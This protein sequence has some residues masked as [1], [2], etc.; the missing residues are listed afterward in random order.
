[1]LASKLQKTYVL[2]TGTVAGPKEGK[3]PFGTDFDLVFKDYYYGTRNFESA[4]EKALKEAANIALTKAKLQSTDIFISGDLNNQIYASSKVASKFDSSYLG[5][6]GACSTSMLGVGIASLLIEKDLVKNALISTSSLLPASERQFRYPNEYGLQKKAETTIT[7]SGAA[8]IILSNT[9]SR[10]KITEVSIGGAKD[11]G[12]DD[13]KD[14]GTAMSYAAFDTIKNHLNYFD[15]HASYYDLILTGDL[16]FYGSKVLEELFISE[17]IKLNNH[18]DS[19]LLLYAKDENV[20]AGGSGAACC[21]LVT[22][23]HIFKELK[24]GR[25]NRVLVV[26]TGALHNPVSVFQK[27]AIPAVA[28]AVVFE[29]S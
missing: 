9:P 12:F 23:T 26:A 20:F 13:V 27:K 6:F 16:S 10:I 28:H 19:G 18:Q 29:R 4:E 14:L 8:S 17:G 24:L 1:M 15:H 3:G 5:L 11:T 22:Y 2:T 25:L 21:P 7:A